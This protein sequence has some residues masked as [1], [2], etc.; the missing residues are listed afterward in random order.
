[1]RFRPVV[2]HFSGRRTP[3]K[4]CAAVVV[5]ILQPVAGRGSP[6]H[7]AIGIVAVRLATEGG[8]ALV[9]VEVGGLGIGAAW[10]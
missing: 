3:H 1:M 10:R 4:W 2:R 9:D 5:E 8:H 7:I 6:D